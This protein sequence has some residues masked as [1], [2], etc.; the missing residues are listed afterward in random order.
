MS[1]TSYRTFLTTT[2]NMGKQERLVNPLYAL[3]VEFNANSCGC[4]VGMEHRAS[5]G[6]RKILRLGE[7]CD[8]I[9]R[10]GQ[11]TTCNLL[12]KAEER[13]VY[14]VTCTTIMPTMPLAFEAEFMGI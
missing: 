12:P 13:L 2:K 4:I 6:H 8:L 7:V 9:S 10:L 5:D 14:E 11:N 1:L 3:C